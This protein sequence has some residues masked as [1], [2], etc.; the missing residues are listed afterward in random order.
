MLTTGNDHGALGE[1]LRGGES[2]DAYCERT[3]TPP[4]EWRRALEGLTVADLRVARVDG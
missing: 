4:A 1:Y 3:E 2:F